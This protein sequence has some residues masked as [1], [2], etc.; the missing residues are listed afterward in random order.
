[1]NGP[2]STACQRSRTA[3]STCSASIRS[4]PEN[5]SSVMRWLR[6]V[7]T[8]AGTPS[9]P[10]IRRCSPRSRRSAIVFDATSPSTSTRSKTRQPPHSRTRRLG[11]PLH[12]LVETPFPR[13]PRCAQSERRGTP[14]RQRLRWWRRRSRRLSRR[15]ALGRSHVP[16]RLHVRSSR[17]RRRHHDRGAARRRGSRRGGTVPLAGTGPAKGARR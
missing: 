6:T 4:S 17:T 3:R 2:R 13:P 11:S 9:S 16:H 7:G 5:S 10:I 8:A 1:M 15:V 12:H 14:P